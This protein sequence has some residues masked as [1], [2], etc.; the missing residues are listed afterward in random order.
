MPHVQ[1]AWCLR[2]GLLRGGSQVLVIVICAN[3]PETSTDVSKH[4]KDPWL[5]RIVKQPDPRY[6]RSKNTAS[7]R[8][9][10]FLLTVA[11]FYR[12][13]LVCLTSVQF[14]VYRSFNVAVIVCIRIGNRL[15]CCRQYPDPLPVEVLVSARSSVLFWG[16]SLRRYWPLYGREWRWLVY[17]VFL[18][19]FP[20]TEQTFGTVQPKILQRP[21]K[22][23]SSVW[24]VSLKRLPTAEVA[25][26]NICNRTV[27]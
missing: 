10:H 26:K 2:D 27:V 6:G 12:N 9:R 18:V 24:V 25:A 15:R 3:C 20:A 23:L 17:L 19:N 11:S 14:A 1:G 7:T 22:D 13:G 16:F 4:F 5:V 8:A 21:T